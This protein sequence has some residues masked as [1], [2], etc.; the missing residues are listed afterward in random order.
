MLSAYKFEACVIRSIPASV[1]DEIIAQGGAGV[2]DSVYIE[3]EELYNININPDTSQPLRELSR[4][5]IKE[6]PRV[7]LFVIVP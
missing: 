1:R 4:D 7:E 6:F 3:S 2:G 5:A